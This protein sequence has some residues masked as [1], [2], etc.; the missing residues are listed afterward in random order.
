MP[1]VLKASQLFPSD[2]QTNRTRLRGSA[3]N[4]DYAAT[5][6]PPSRRPTTQVFDSRVLSYGQ[7]PTPR[8]KSWDRGSDLMLSRSG[9][10]LSQTKKS[11]R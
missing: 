6:M 3:G 5:R 11:E 10:T 2:P 4:W 7:S 8:T 9:S 1:D